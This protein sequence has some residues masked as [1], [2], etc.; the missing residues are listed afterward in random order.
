MP[1][2]PRRIEVPDPVTVRALQALSAAQKWELA[3]TMVIQARESIGFIVRAARPHWSDAE[4]RTE[5]ARR[6]GC[7][8]A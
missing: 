5:V 6:M 8:T 7:G 2:D 1:I 3:N 4:V